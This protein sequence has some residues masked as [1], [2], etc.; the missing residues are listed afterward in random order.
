MSPKR[1]AVAL[2]VWAFVPLAAVSAQQQT[3]TTKADP[4][5]CWWRTSTGAVRV[6][7]TFSAVL[8]CAVLETPDV[9]VVADQSKLEPS[10]VQFAPFEVTGGSHAADL[11]T[12]DRRFFQDEYTLRLIAEN[13]F[14]KDAQIPETKISYRV[15][16]HTGQSTAA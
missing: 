3:Q 5:Q 14:G 12:D 7:D 8:T 15:Q 2:A 4:I 1:V 6:G 13:L 16:S 11:R 9:K 10:V